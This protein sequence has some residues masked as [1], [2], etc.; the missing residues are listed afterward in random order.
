MAQG[1]SSSLSLVA[2]MLLLACRP[3]PKPT[4]REALKVKSILT[5]YGNASGQVVNYEKSALFFSKNTKERMKQEISES[6]DNMKEAVNGTY[7]GLPMAI[8]RSK[9]QVFGFVKNK[10]SSKLQGWKQRLL[11]EGGKEVLIKAVTMAM[12]T[13]VMAC[14]R[15]P[16]GLCRE[17][18]RK[19]AKFWW[20]KGEREASIHWASWKKL[21]EVKG[22]G[23]LGFRDLEAFNTS[24]LAKQ[25][26]RFLT[27][28]NLLVSKVM[29]V[30][31]MKNPNWMNKGPP[32]S[33]SWSWKSIH[34]AKNLLLAGLWKRIGDGRTISIWKDRW[35]IGSEDGKVEA[36]KT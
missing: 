15:L 27:A 26:W 22:R 6:L 23:G 13:Y 1:S 5:K 7:L 28:L 21:S 20:G 29:K 18:T 9:A 3:R 8:G 35:V 31:Y 14:F 11:S 17:I 12:P 16:K 34:S 33:A 2:L 24:L 30:K 32:G 25:I 36:E 10:I 19:I 4:K